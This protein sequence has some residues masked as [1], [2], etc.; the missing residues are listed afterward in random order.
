[1]PDFNCR[2]CGACCIPSTETD[3]YA[4]LEE[5]ETVRL[6]RA[7]KAHLFGTANRSLPVLVWAEEY[8][9]MR[10]KTIK[11]GG[12]DVTVCAAFEGEIGKKCSCSVYGIRPEVCRA[13]RP[14]SKECLGAREEAE[15]L[16]NG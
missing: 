12:F 16:L 13:F 14:G 10:T 8:F 11:Q 2:K 1:M 4:T 9:A 7:G 6:E 15:A 5:N 3:L